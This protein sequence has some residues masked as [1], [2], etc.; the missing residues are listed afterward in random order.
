MTDS[1]HS[2]FNE[3]TVKRLCSNVSITNKQKRSAAEWIGLLES[4]A[5]DKEKQNYFKFALVVLQDILGYD[6][7]RRLD[8]EKWKVE[9]SFRGINDQGGVCIEVKGLLTKD[10][11]SPQS[12]EKMEHK[13]P[14]KQ[15]WDYMGEG[16]FEH[17]IAT[18]YMHFVLINK[19]HA[20][21][22]FHR[23]N[24]M[25]IKNDP[26]KLKEFVAVFS[27][28]SIINNGFVRKLYAES[29]IQDR[30]FSKQ[31]YKLYHETRLMLIKE[32]QYN[33]KITKQEAIH[34]AQLFLNRLIFVFFA[35]D[36]EKLRKRVF[37][38]SVLL[39]LNAAL[40][41]EYSKRVYETIIDLFRQIDK[42]SPSQGIFG[43]NG[44]LFATE[45]PSNIYFNDLRDKSFFKDVLQY[46]KLKDHP[47]LDSNSA[48][49]VHTYGEKLSPLIRNLLIM[50]SYD[51]QSDLN[52]NI[53]GHIFEQSISDLEELGS[54]E[55]NSNKEKQQVS[56]QR[57]R[58]QKEGIFYTPEYIT[59][60]ICRNTIL[61]CL[62]KKGSTN[63]DEVA[64]EYKD[65]I[66][67]LEEKFRSVKIVDPACGSG[68]FLIKAI[69]ILLEVYKRIQMV[70]ESKGKYFVS[71][72]NRKSSGYSELVT[73][74]KWNEQ[75][76]ARKI[77]ENNIFGVDRI[78]SQ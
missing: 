71:K 61:P 54:S 18:N 76:E 33:S 17:G 35:E 57:S 13:T 47:P 1:S 22:K 46:S 74:E 48:A 19:E 55:P 32:F 68:A 11:F 40:V 30:E 23:F 67:E 39:S 50:G 70:K 43:F 34:F 16:N 41:S 53:L 64:E 28:E 26:E 14:I 10:L 44:G 45:I 7:R 6:I 73:L 63:V 9:F 58:R 2:L 60:F 69:D 78:R 25:D 59:D 56:G 8:H 36:T 3:K 65:N 24:F 15:T 66:E 75:E 4:G 49:A 77:I 52:V 27:K 72:R 51:F 42:G 20:L 31:F 12:R 38:E 21:T 5:L 62:S 29:V 37:T